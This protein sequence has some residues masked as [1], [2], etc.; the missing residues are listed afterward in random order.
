LNPSQFLSFEPATS[1]GLYAYHPLTPADYSAF[2]DIKLD[3]GAYEFIDDK[4][5]M[6][7]PAA[8]YFGL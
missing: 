7:K 1:L 2:D 5:K 4:I 3:V 6:K 8:P